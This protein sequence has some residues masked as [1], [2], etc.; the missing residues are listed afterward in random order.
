MARISVSWPLRGTSRETHT[1]TGRSVRPSRARTGVAAG[2]GV[3]GLLVDARRQ[4]DHPRGRP[5]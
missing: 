3:E 2:P 1:T 4:M 5:G